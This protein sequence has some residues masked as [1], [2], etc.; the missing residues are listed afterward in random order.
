M[1]VVENKVSENVDKI[2]KLSYNLIHIETKQRQRNLIIYGLV[3]EDRL[4]TYAHVGRFLNDWLELD[5]DEMN[6]ENCD[7]LGRYVNNTQFRQN[8]PN[9]VE[10]RY[11]EDVEAC[12]RKVHRLAG[13][14]YVYAID[15]DYPA[16][17]QH[18]RKRIWSEYKRLKQANNRNVVKLLYPAAISVNGVVEINVFPG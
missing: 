12:I 14:R 11:K 17:I 15:R 18:A 7:R 5:S 8:I 3:E 1:D 16:E 4:S 2:T 6:I 13:T 9:L 10:F